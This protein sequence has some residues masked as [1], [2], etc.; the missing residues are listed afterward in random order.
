[1]KHTVMV[2]NPTARAMTTTMQLCRCQ[3]QAAWVP[4]HHDALAAHDPGSDDPNA[5][6]QRHSMFDHNHDTHDDDAVAGTPY[7]SCE[8]HVTQATTMM[9]AT[10]ITAMTMPPP[11]SALPMQVASH[12]QSQP[13]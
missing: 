5:A 10:P 11:G 3:P 12:M 6:A 7:L 9:R 8:P 13:Q 4:D 1:M 2:D